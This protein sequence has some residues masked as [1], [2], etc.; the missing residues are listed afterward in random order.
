[1]KRGIVYSIIAVI[2]V[3]IILDIKVSNEKPKIL[4]KDSLD[5]NTIGILDDSN[6]EFLIEKSDKIGILLVHG[7]GASPYQTKELANFIA[8]KNITV[9]SIRLSGH[10]TNLDDMESKSFKDWYSDVEKGFDFLK[11]KTKKVYVLG[12]SSGASL[13]LELAKNRNTDGLIVIAPP[14]YLTS[15][16]A[17]YAFIIKYFKRYTYTGTDITQIGHSYENLP[18]KSLAEFVG[19][20]KKSSKNLEKIDQPILIIQSYKDDIVMPKSA[21]YVYENINSSEKEILWVNSIKHGIIRVYEDD[22]PESVAERQKI[23]NLIYY[24]LVK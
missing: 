20:I 7:L 18:I 19:L 12:V 21:E 14:I 23:F 8:D 22:T 24:F 5:N 13:S 17:K 4:Y 10:G 15:K 6:K 11:N 1:M 2:L 9:Y 16:A 3:I